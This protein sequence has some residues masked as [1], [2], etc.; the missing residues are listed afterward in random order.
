MTREQYNRYSELTMREE[1]GVVIQK[2]INQII[3]TMYMPVHDERQFVV[4][5]DIIASKLHED[6]INWSNLHCVDVVR[7]QEYNTYQATIEEAGEDSNNLIAYIESLLFSWG[8]QVE[9]VCCW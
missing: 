4:S 8:W 9:V 6:P 3:Q 7:G 5:A 2:L 1:A